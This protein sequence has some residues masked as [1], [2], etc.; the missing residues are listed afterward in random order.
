MMGSGSYNATGAE[1]GGEE[2]TIA[3]RGVGGVRPV[4]DRDSSTRP[5]SRGLRNVVTCSESNG[6]G[7]DTGSDNGSGAGNTRRVSTGSPREERL[8]LQLGDAESVNVT[9]SRSGNG[10]NNSI[11]GVAWSPRSGRRSTP[12][13]LSSASCPSPRHLSSPHASGLAPRG[14]DRSGTRNTEL[15]VQERSSRLSK[16]E[17]LDIYEDGGGSC[18]SDD[19]DGYKTALNMTDDNTRNNS[20]SSSS[21]NSESALIETRGSV[22]LPAIGR[23]GGSAFLPDTSRAGGGRRGRGSSYSH[24]DSHDGNGNEINRP[25][26]YHFH[27]EKN[28]ADKSGNSTNH[29]SKTGDGNAVVSPAAVGAAVVGDANNVVLS[30]GD[31]GGYYDDDFDEFLEEDFQDDV[32]YHHPQEQQQ[33]TRR[34]Q[35]QDNRDATAI[36]TIGGVKGRERTIVGRASVVSAPVRGVASSGVVESSSSKRNRDDKDIGRSV[37]AS[38]GSNGG[39]DRDFDLSA[40]GVSGR[41]LKD[42]NNIPRRSAEGRG[43][44]GGTKS[45]EKR[46]QVGQACYEDHHHH[47]H[48]EDES[49]T[50]FVEVVYRPPSGSSRGVTKGERPKSAA[51]QGRSASLNTGG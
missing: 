16:E 48:L 28:Y 10:S 25:E 47:N 31:S 45:V 1:V 44:A 30:G 37:S 32:D 4:N 8:R 39:R 14:D 43:G 21:N 26:K 18:Q 50:P 12:R 35:Q 19:S 9:S 13:R 38:C 46:K 20:S 3:R 23:G 11:I 34:R 22:N 2:M 5:V 40:V 49:R 51:R 17:E 7:R 27:Q 36:S 33:Q 42:S 41:A 24:G 15:V 6:M 29:D